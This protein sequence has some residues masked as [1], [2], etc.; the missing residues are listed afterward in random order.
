MGLRHLQVKKIRTRNK[1]MVCILGLVVAFYSGLWFVLEHMLHG[2]ADQELQQLNEQGQRVNCENL[3]K[4]GY[5]LRVGLAC[6]SLRWQDDSG[7]YDLLTGEIVVAA[8]LYAPSWRTLE[9]GSPTFLDLAD[10]TQIRALWQNLTLSAD[11]MDEPPD[12][13]SVTI[14]DLQLSLTKA[15]EAAPLMLEQFPKTGSHFSE[16][17]LEADFV[18]LQFKNDAAGIKINLS[19]DALRLPGMMSHDHRQ[20]PAMTGEMILSFDPMPISAAEA[21]LTDVDSWQGM[22]GLSGRL[23]KLGLNFSSGGG[24]FTEGDFQIA[25]S[26][27][28]SGQFNVHMLDMFALLRTVRMYFPSQASN[29]ETVFFVLNTMPKDEQGNPIITIS[30]DEGRMRAGFIPLGHLPT[31]RNSFSN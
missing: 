11:F 4:T 27:T 13:V 5:P 3:R 29:L 24:F 19:F 9:L 14:E 8:P 26:G 10:S 18:R 2:V 31:F 17:A 6:D 28:L 22:R 7:R 1:R 23:E 30:I 20:D 25:D 15:G 21:D 12:A 16:N